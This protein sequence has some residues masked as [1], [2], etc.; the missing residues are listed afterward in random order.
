MLRGV[1]L[2]CRSRGELRNLDAND[3]P[4]GDAFLGECL[5]EGGGTGTELGTLLGVFL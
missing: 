1:D 5:T 3:L 4:R 2:V